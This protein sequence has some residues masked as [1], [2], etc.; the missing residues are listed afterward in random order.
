M[1]CL[2]FQHDGTATA[3]PAPSDEREAM[4]KLP[5]HLGINVAEDIDEEA[6]AN[7]ERV[8]A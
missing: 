1:S 4:E 8:V 5:F 6:H 2:Y 7:L 3:A